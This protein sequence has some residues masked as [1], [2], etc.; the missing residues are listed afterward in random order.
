LIARRERG[1]ATIAAIV[2]VVAFGFIAFE[3]LA[4]NRGVLAEVR[5]EA[6]NAKLIAAAD[7]GLYMAIAGLATSDVT[8]RWGIDGR[9]RVVQFLDT[10]LTI[11]VEDERGKIPLNGII[12]EEV[13]DMFVDLGVTGT[14][15]DT[16]TDSYEDWQDTDNSA[17]P[18]GAEAA[19]YA[20]MGYKPRN[21][22]F[23]TL[24]EL[25][26]LKGMD[27]A[28]YQ[29]VA[30]AATVF[31]GE[32]GGFS[33]ST[34]QP[35]A[36]EVLGETTANSREVIERVKELAGQA[37][38]P[39]TLAKASLLARTLTVR[40]EARKGTTYLKRTAII[41]LIGNNGPGYWIRYLD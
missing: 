21:A 28:L 27:D 6:E 22:G 8:Q 19:A 34:S 7:A 15:L 29:Q 39:Q 40:I 32:S 14:R 12:E 23:R 10:T 37:P 30:P 26:M 5:G 16:L 31:F 18:A 9:G 36:L 35:L 24:G 2:G 11:T 25:R 3:L 13:R 41:E 33:E 4:Q 20:P 17:R 38:V 1:Y